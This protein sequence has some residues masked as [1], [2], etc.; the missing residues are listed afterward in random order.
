MDFT[1]LANLGD[2]VGGVAVLVTLVYLAIQV[3]QGTSALSSSRHHDMLEFIFSNNYS[4][5]SKDREYAEFILRAEQSPDE[6]DETDWYRFVL[7]AYGI[8]AAWEDAY[9]SHRRSLIDVE[10]W[11]AWEGASLPT[12]TAIERATIV[13]W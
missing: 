9:I 7:Y 2:F 8:Y 5:V 6:L 4:P 3:K 10:V 12:S 13:T 11:K 1:Q